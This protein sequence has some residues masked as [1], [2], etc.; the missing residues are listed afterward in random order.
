MTSSDRPASG[1]C[2]GKE[3]RGRAREDPAQEASSGRLLLGPSSWTGGPGRW[4][5]QG[6]AQFVAADVGVEAELAWP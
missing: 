2:G 4:D 1:C 5:W 3:L 6:W